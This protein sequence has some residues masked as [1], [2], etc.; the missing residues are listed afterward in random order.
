MLSESGINTF[1]LILYFQIHHFLDF[2]KQIYRDLPRVVV[3]TSSAAGGF[4]S[5]GGSFSSDV[6]VLH[7]GSWWVFAPCSPSFFSSFFHIC[8]LFSSPALLPFSFSFTSLFSS[9]PAVSQYVNFPLCAPAGEVLW[10]PPGDSGKHSS[11]S[12]NGGDDHLGAR[13]DSPWERR[14]WNTNGKI[15]NRL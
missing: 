3:S 2:V 8:H 9:H 13:E 11:F 6:I 7:T 12:R 10:E 15:T 1:A 14:Q 5:S 4:A